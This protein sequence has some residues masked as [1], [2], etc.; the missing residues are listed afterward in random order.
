MEKEKSGKGE[1]ADICKIHSSR[2][3]DVK[4]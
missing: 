1:E 2:R 4:I 3:E